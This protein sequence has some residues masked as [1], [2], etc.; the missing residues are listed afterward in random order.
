[1][2]KIFIESSSNRR[3][4]VDRLTWI[5]ISSHAKNIREY[6]K[7]IKER[8]NLLKE[9]SADNTWY[10]NLEKQIVKFGTEIIINRFKVIKLLTDEIEKN[11]INFP[12]GKIMFKGDIEKKYSVNSKL[13]KHNKILNINSSYE[14]WLL[15]LKKMKII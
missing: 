11:D 14:Y 12:K 4:F 1:M 3:K 8:N 10:S 2:D 6:E 13:Y 15:N 9:N 5:F 7:V